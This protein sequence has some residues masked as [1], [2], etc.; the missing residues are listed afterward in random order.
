MRARF[1]LAIGLVAASTA[2]A[3]SSVTLFGTLDATLSRYSVKGGPSQTV[4][5]NS[6][7]NNSAL[8]FRGTEDLGGGLW[9]GFWLEG[10][11]ANDEGSP[12][13]FNFMRRSTVSLGGPWG[14][15]RL[16]RDFTPT[17]WND[18][19]FDP[20]G[21]SG[22]GSNI[23]NQARGTAT[24]PGR[25]LFAPGFGANNPNYIRASNSV[26]YFLPR[27]LGGVYGQVQYAL[28]EQSAAGSQQGRFV[29]ARLGYA[30]GP[31]NTAVAMSTSAGSHPTTAGAPD[32]R[33]AN[34]GASYDFGVLR[35]MA[36]V[37]RESYE[38]AGAR[39]TGKGY[40]V[41][42]QVPMGAVRFRVAY[43]T[44]KVDRAGMPRAGKLALGA[45][46]DLSKRTA[47]YATY[48]RINN[49]NTA[50]LPVGGSATGPAGAATTGI[51]LGIRH[52]F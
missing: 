38:V 48:A 35:G 18:A 1:L 5:A 32:I 24:L 30:N 23:I 52:N 37:T 31:L 17:F 25:M 41:G 6:G 10:A 28:H 12:N 22:A 14:E 21:A 39:S 49:G 46:Y 2:Q 44:W 9:T 47:L 15:V 19:I 27:T 8:G 34:L 29:G 36:E 13:G 26:A 7:L 45:V 11:V 16:G 42:V 40:L 50:L 51:D 33:S 4:L 3:Q 20:F 43:S